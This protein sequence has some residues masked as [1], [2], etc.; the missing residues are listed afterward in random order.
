MVG[1]GTGNETGNEKETW[2]E[3]ET[4]TEAAS[5]NQSETE[6]GSGNLCIVIRS[7]IYKLNHN[8]IVLCTLARFCSRAT[9]GFRRLVRA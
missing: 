8:C 4:G 3:K 1:T 5:T 6:D 2:N 9:L 7:Y